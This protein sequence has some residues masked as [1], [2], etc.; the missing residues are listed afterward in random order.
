LVQSAAPEQS[1]IVQ[2]ITDIDDVA[3]IKKGIVGDLKRAFVTRQEALPPMEKEIQDQDIPP[4][5]TS[6]LQVI[7]KE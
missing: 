4:T 6:D 1:T 2:K 3:E 7:L 5:V